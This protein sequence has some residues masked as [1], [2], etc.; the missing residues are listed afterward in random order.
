MP[1]HSIARHFAFLPVYGQKQTTLPYLGRQID[2]KALALEFEARLAFV[3]SADLTVKKLRFLAVDTLDEFDDADER[4]RFDA[5][6]AF[7]TM[8]LDRF[9]ARLKN[10]FGSV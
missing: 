9:L 2:A 3:L 5:N 7:M 6:F 1:A 4:V 8:E 10:E